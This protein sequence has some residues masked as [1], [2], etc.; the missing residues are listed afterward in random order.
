L[1]CSVLFCLIFSPSSSFS[2]AGSSSSHIA[3]V[4]TSISSP[5]SS[6]VSVFP[7]FAGAGFADSFLLLFVEES[8]V[9]ETEGPAGLVSTSRET[10]GPAGIHPT[11]FTPSRF[12]ILLGTKANLK[13]CLYSPSREVEGGGAVE[14]EASQ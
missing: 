8:V 7:F 6:S 10:I 9:W 5:Q 2:S 4:S 12:L 11:I 1:F 14:D 3:S 13:D